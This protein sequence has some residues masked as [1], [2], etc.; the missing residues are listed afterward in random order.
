[1]KSNGFNPER[2]IEIVIVN[3]KKIIWDGHHWARAAGAAGIKEVP[4]KI[5]EKSPEVMSKLWHQAAE[6]ASQLGLPF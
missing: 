6:A 1:M 5:L 3:G 2:A 4:V